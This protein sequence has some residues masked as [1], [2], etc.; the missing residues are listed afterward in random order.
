M[1]VNGRHIVSDLCAD[2]EEGFSSTVAYKWNETKLVDGKEVVEE[3]SIVRGPFAVIKDAVKYASSWDDPMNPP[4]VHREDKVHHASHTSASHKPKATGT[5][6]KPEPAANPESDTP[7]GPD[8][9]HA[10]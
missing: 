9:D 7:P 5:H 2:S 4:P 10:E 8:S 1:F 6:H 3:K